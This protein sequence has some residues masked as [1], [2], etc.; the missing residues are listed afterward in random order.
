[1]LMCSLECAFSEC[2]RRAGRSPSGEHTKAAVTGDQTSH[3]GFGSRT[4]TTTT[5]STESVGSRFAGGVVAIRGE[6]KV[7]IVASEVSGT[8]GVAI[9]AGRTLSV[10]EGHDTST[11][12]ADYSRTK[13]SGF[14]DPLLAVKKTSGS[15]FQRIVCSQD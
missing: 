9:T 5:A 2:R 14:D 3:R 11:S 10:V 1:M 4:T 15:S 13:K 6:G 7:D 8:D 12:R